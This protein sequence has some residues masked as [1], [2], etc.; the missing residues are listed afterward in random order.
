MLSNLP[1]FRIITLNAQ[2]DASIVPERLIAM[3]SGF[4]ASLGALLAG[5]GIYGLLA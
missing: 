2:M 1:T 5:I 3:L 4:F